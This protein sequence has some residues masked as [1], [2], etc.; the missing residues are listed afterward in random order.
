[1]SQSPLNNNKNTILIL[2]DQFI[3]Y[4]R[5]PPVITN[6][7][8]GFNL[9]RQEG[10]VF[11]N[12]RNNR[13]MCSPSRST[14]FTSRI[15]HGVQDNIDQ[16]YQYETISQINNKYDN[17]AKV[18]KRNKINIC[19][20]YGKDHFQSKEA[21]D[22]FNIPGININSNGTFRQ[23]DFDRNNLY[24]DS[25]YIP[26]K[27]YLADSLYFNTQVN[28][29]IENYDY[30]DIEGV[31]SVG[32]L[33]F[34]KARAK[35]G[36][37]FHAQFHLTNPH[38]T[39]EFWDN[40]SQVP[41]TSRN[42]YWAP[43][44][45]EQTTFKGIQNP[46]VYNEYF[47]D[48]F[49]TDLELTTNFF[50]TLFKDYKTNKNSLPN[51]N[52][53][54][55]DYVTNPKLNSIDGTMVSFQELY[56]F[57]FTL[58]DNQDD[59][60]SW[61]NLI[62]NY[63]G[64]LLLSDEYVYSIIMFLKD[65]GMI[66]NTNLVVTSDHGEQLC[67]HGLKQKYVHFDESQRTDVYILSNM[68]NPSFIGKQF[69]VLGSTLDINPTVETLAN[70]ENPSSDFLGTSLLVKNSDGTL[71]PRKRHIDSFNVVNATMYAN[72]F[73]YFKP[74]Y[75]LQNDDTK[76]KVLNIPTNFGAFKYL[77]ISSTIVENNS[78]YKIS[79]YFNFNALLDYNFKNKYNKKVSFSELISYIDT[80]D[81]NKYSKIIQK[82]KSKLYNND[83]NKKYYLLFILNFTMEDA[84][85][86]D[87]D[88]SSLLYLIL[89]KVV[90]NDLNNIVY[91]PGVLGESFI[92]QYEKKD[93][94]YYYITS[95]KND[96]DEINNLADP[97][98]FNINDIKTLNLFETLNTK[99]QKLI[100]K[101]QCKNFFYIPPIISLRSLLYYFSE[102]DSGQIPDNIPLKEIFFL[103][104]FLSNN[105]F[106]TSS[107]NYAG[108]DK[109]NIS[110]K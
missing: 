106:D 89:C 62:N 67:A 63:F 93:F 21:Y 20:Y 61:K 41:K 108:Q 54:L 51:L 68:I 12:I 1:M 4:D 22:V 80:K 36:Q 45:E 16:N 75:K 50:E 58:A 23:F 6:K 9:L 66:E 69:N 55:N 71:V 87:T 46:Y 109:I 35:D 28:N 64:L 82:V 92:Q 99:Q 73:I 97:N 48:A 31:R 79:K 5:L 70:I 42:Q 17:L 57:V 53:Y 15:N 52:S 103:T 32:I 19:G 8:K 3:S 81:L 76:S 37:S 78:I 18:L 100:S 65:S 38:D 102:N 7:L 29:K 88:L 24:G 104:S 83:T 27:G 40:L 90:S 34:L 33:P 49:A 59:V 91:L 101:F 39:Q 14:I 105:N 74:W 44:L 11:Q 2:L 95:F 30:I 96:R 43:F 26:Q 72:S 85:N 110:G 10:I 86:G 107:R 47:Q 25:F 13:Q 98:K 56:K 84:R 60:K 94:I 77:Y